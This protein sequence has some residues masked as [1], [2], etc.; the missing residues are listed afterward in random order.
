MLSNICFSAGFAFLPGVIESIRIENLVGFRNG[1]GLLR[2]DRSS[3]SFHLSIHIFDLSVCLSKGV[4]LIGL[5][6]TVRHLCHRCYVCFPLSCSRVEARVGKKKPT[7]PHHTTLIYK[8]FT[9]HRF[10][11]RFVPSSWEGEEDKIRDCH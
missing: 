10:H 6:V 9:V 11:V 3:V 4:D 2:T 1:K 5:F 7:R 8:Y